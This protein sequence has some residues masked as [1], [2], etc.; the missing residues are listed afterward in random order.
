MRI[1]KELRGDETFIGGKRKNKNMSHA[2]RKA[3]KGRGPV[4]KT[5]VAGAKDRATGRVVAHSVEG[6]DSGAL[7]GFVYRKVER[8]AQVFTDEAG[9]C[10]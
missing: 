7:Q 4:G 5:T 8:G 1:C 2:R 10:R 3:R 9:A 6:T